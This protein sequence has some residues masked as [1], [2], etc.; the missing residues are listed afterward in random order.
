MK[1]ETLLE[2]YLKI[3]ECARNRA[4]RDFAI[5]GI[6]SAFNKLS[7]EEQKQAEEILHQQY[8]Q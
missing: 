8:I 2:I 4:E 6:E 3:L 1:A 7:V 5:K